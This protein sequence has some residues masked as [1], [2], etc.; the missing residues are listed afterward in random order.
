MAL[1][2]ARVNLLSL[3]FSLL[4][5]RE[6]SEGGR[7]GENDFPPKSGRKKPLYLEKKCHILLCRHA[8]RTIV[9]VGHFFWGEGEGDKIDTS[10]ILF[11]QFVKE[12]GDKTSLLKGTGIKKNEL[13]QYGMPTV[14]VICGV[15]CG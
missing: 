9:P 15:V 12:K 8:R 6:K 14:I 11:A 5:A 7:K 4:E 2:N 3:S 1:A 13:G 10:L